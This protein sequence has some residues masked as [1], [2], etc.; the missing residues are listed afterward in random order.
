MI[1]L[2]LHHKGATKENGGSIN[3]SVAPVLDRLN[4]ILAEC[5]GSYVTLDFIGYTGGRAQLLKLWSNN[6]NVGFPS[7]AAPQSVK[8]SWHDY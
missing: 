2:K 5:T 7:P 3:S 8:M 6:Q 1:S 4:S